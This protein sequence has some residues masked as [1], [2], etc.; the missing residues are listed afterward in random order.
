[1]LIDAVFKITIGD[2]EVFSSIEY[3]C[4]LKVDILKLLENL[5]KI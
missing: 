2:Y 5:L 1:M 3:S 4:E